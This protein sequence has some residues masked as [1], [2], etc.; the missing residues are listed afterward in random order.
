MAPLG[1]LLAVAALR[2]TEGM[3]APGLECAPAGVFAR[4]HVERGEPLLEA[5][6][7][8]ALSE[9]EGPGALARMACK[10]VRGEADDSLLALSPPDVLHRWTDVELDELRWPPLAAAARRDREW[11]ARAHAAHADA[12][13]PLARFADALDVCRGH[14]LVHG[15]ALHLIPGVGAF[16]WSAVRGATLERRGRTFRLACTEAREA[17]ALVTISAGWRTNDE[18]LLEQGWASA[19]LSSDSAVL[20]ADDVLERVRAHQPD[21]PDGG[22]GGGDVRG[23][24]AEV[25]RALRE[26]RYLHEDEGDELRVLSGGYASDMLGILLQAACLGAELTGLSGASDRP[27]LAAAISIGE[28]V[29]LSLDHEVRVGA[30]LQALCESALAVCTDDLGADE[31]RLA[32]LEGGAARAP[33]IGPPLGSDAGAESRAAE[34]LRARISR[35]RCLAACARRAA[36]W[37]ARPSSVGSLRRPWK[38]NV[39]TAG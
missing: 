29:I 36:A 1:V 37:V 6:A 31:A 13:V 8:A 18:L 21:E 15:G 16:G 17:G 25:M 30:A 7:S 2:A 22:G 10:L 28:G 19:D 11:I 9:P 33:G 5:R 38:V 3:L 23:L 12:G 27:A 24:R 4:R 20:T 32:A 14:A 34:A 35:A 39:R 26:L